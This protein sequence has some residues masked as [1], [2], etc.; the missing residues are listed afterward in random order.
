MA[1]FDLTTEE[2][3]AAYWQQQQR[4]RIAYQH[5]LWLSLQAPPEPRQ[6]VIDAW[7]PLTL[8]IAERGIEIDPKDDV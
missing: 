7:M 3:R 1:S 8:A 4:D 5:E 2:G 6:R